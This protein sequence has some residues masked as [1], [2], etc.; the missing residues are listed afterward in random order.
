MRLTS[1]IPGWEVQ[2]PGSPHL[3]GVLRGEGVGP[4]VIDGALTVL[5]AVQEATP[6]RF[7]L[8]FGG[9]IGTTAEKEYGQVLPPGVAD[10]CR[11]IFDRRGALLC[12]PGGSRFVYELRARFD[13]F[14]KLIPIRPTPA[15][16][17]AGSM[18]PEAV[19]GVDLLVI[20]EHAGGIYFGQSGETTHAGVR[21]A[22]HHFHYDEPAVRRI[23]AVAAAAARMRR[24]RLC[25]IHKPAGIPA[26]SRLWQDLAT[27]IAADLELEKLEVDT[28]NYRLLV[29]ASH[30][31][32]VVA[33]NL[34]GD[35]LADGAAALLATR[36]MSYSSNHSD[37]LVG[38]YQT[39]HGAAYDLAGKDRANPLGQVL[40][41]AMM[42]HEN[43]GLDSAAAAI[44][45]AIDD[46]LAAGWRTA[47][48]MEKG[49][50]LV[51]TREMSRRVAEAVRRKLAAET[52]ESARPHAPVTGG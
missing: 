23:L 10:F 7:N 2:S 28:A 47:D 1:V 11:G 40:S 49:A 43:F 3:V 9:S 25:V 37:G 4:E 30:F 21:R 6:H 41:L 50:R 27:D 35:V 39:A 36:G 18:R 22:F 48:I 34:F 31:D 38:V 12:G 29:D 42:L 52:M 15:L 26:I 16:R 45:A 5:A 14:C 44:R 17:G 8:E 20:R 51:G 46:V 24:G 13:L 32:V 33:P 19:A